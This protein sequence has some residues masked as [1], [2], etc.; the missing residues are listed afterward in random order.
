MLSEE[1]KL[2]DQVI[3]GLENLSSQK[4]SPRR[5]CLSLKGG[6]MARKQGKRRGRR[7]AE[8]FCG[9]G[10]T[11][12]DVLI[13][14]ISSYVRDDGDGVRMILPWLIRRM[15]TPIRTCAACSMSPTRRLIYPRPTSSTRDRLKL[16][17]VVGWS[18][19]RCHPE[20]VATPERRPRHLN[21]QR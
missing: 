7:E 15:W 2:C 3:V 5:I 10:G 16:V 12:D 17:E 14:K 19:R 13:L 20:S 18:C 6:T 9:A 11:L 4:K 1:N 21:K 8:G